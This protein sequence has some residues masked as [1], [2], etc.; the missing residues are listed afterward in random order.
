MGTEPI[1]FRGGPSLPVEVVEWL[2]HV[3]G[4]LAF[5]TSPAGRL[6]VDPMPAPGDD[7]DVFIRAHRD[8]VY[9]AVA[10]RERVCAWPLASIGTR[11]APSLHPPARPAIEPRP[12]RA[13]SPAAVPPAPVAAPRQ[14]ALHA[15]AD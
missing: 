11:L 14:L 7:D 5:Q 4:R 12:V 9:A 15:E 10:Y 13:S 8:D 3:D 6:L 2:L 1:P